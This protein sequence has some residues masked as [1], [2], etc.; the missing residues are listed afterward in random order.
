MSAVFA[1]LVTVAAASTPSAIEA[2]AGFNTQIGMRGDASEASSGRLRAKI[3]VTPDIDEFW[4][5]W[6][7]PTP[8]NIVTTGMVTQAK[9]VH[10]IILF[11]GCTPGADGLCKLSVTFTITAPD[12]SPYGK[13]VSGQAWSGPAGG[14]NLLASSA[15]FGFRLEPKDKLGHYQ[16]KA[17]LTDEI[18]RISVAMREGV[19]AKTD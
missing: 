9:P 6:E 19:V 10:A 12:G 2:Q 7:G 16:M 13:P 3:L 8:P 4:K 17:T 18:A 11:G 15:S 1:V 14:D 5:A